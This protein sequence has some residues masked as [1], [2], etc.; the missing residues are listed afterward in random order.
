MRGYGGISKVQ[1][2]A[3]RRRIEDFQCA[4]MDPA[5]LAEQ[6]LRQEKAKREAEVDY[7]RLMDAIWAAIPIALMVW[8]VFFCLF[9]Y[10]YR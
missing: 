6:I 8:L 9:H 3:A 4:D 5:T 7:R 2:D 1:V 10:F